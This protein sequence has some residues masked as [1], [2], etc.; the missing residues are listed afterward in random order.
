MGVS[1]SAATTLTV[2]RLWKQRRLSLLT[3]VL[4]FWLRLLLSRSLLLITCILRLASRP[5]MPHCLAATTSLVLLLQ[6]WKMK[7]MPRSVPVCWLRLLLSRSQLLTTCTLRLALLPQTQLNSAATTSPVLLPPKLKMR[8]M[9]RS[10]LVC[11]ERLLV[12]RCLLWIT[13]IPK[14][15]SLPLMPLPLVATTS[16]A[17]LRMKLTRLRSRL[18]V[19]NHRRTWQLFKTLLLQSKEQIFPAPNLPNSALRTRTLGLGRSLHPLST[20]LASLR[21]SS[22]VIIW[23][24]CGL[25]QVLT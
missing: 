10:V 18:T 11:W 1:A 7:R 15:V 6:R 8:R 25:C 23:G 14:L 17:T 19:L 20:C 22:F 2:L 21:V 9:P 12:S 16:T 24:H 13:C 3:S 5:L 4:R